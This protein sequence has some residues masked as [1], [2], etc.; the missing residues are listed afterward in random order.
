MFSKYS[1]DNWKEKLYLCNLICSKIQKKEHSFPICFYKANTKIWQRKHIRKETTDLSLMNCCCSVTKL[2]P[3]LC[4]PMAS[5]S[6]NICSNSGPLSQWYHL[7]ISTSAT[8]FFFCL[9]SFPASWTSLV[10]QMVKRQPTMRKTQV[11]SLGWEDP[12]EKVMPTRP[13]TLAW[14]IPGT[15]ECGRLQFMGSQRAGQDW[16]TSLSFSSL[17]Q[18]QG[19]FQWVA[20]CIR[21]PKYWSFGISPSNNDLGLIYFRIDSLQAKGLSR[22]FSGTT[23]L[24]YQ[25]FSIQPSLRYNSHICTW[26]LEKPQLWLDKPLSGK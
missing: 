20:L 7:S 1:F 25:F 23:I 15:Q 16:E 10:A 21:W 6:P 14:K 2:C 24:K 5:L 18:H 9:Q 4:D 17:S 26:L 22:V 11:Q 19:L 3:T 8:L 13:S 12:L